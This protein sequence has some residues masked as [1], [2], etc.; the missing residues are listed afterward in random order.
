MP[1]LKPR[2]IRF[3]SPTAQGEGSFVAF[4]RPTWQAVR[5]LTVTGA[6]GAAAQGEAIVVDLEQFLC[7]SL[8]EWNWQDDDG[9]PLP[10]PKTSAEL[11]ALAAE[12]ITFLLG[13]CQSLLGTGS[14]A[15]P[16]N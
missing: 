1:R 2:V 12:E 11:Q 6:G 13:C 10:L 9:Q 7:T 4:N 14:V 3:D 16:K 15:A 8:A 5:S